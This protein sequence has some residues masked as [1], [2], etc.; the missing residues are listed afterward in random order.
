MEH[1]PRDANPQSVG[2]VGLSGELA[3]EANIAQ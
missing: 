3:G 2:P 1:P